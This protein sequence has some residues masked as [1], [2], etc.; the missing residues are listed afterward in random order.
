[1]NIRVQEERN[2]KEKTM[3]NERQW[4]QN[5]FQLIIAHKDNLLIEVKCYQDCHVHHIKGYIDSINYKDEHIAIVDR[6]GHKDFTII[7]FNDMIDV[8][9]L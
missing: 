5:C 7:K 2:T 6:L 4:K 8:F 1:M 3:L 9:I